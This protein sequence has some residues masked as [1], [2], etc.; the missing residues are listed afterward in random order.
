MS[1]WAPDESDFK[2]MKNLCTDSEFTNYTFVY[3]TVVDIDHPHDSVM[4]MLRNGEAD[5]LLIEA[6]DAAMF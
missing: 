1:G 4:K 5:V 6:E 3:P 2:N